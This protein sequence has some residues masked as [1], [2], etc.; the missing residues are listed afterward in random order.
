MSP[1]SEIRLFVIVPVYGNWDDTL[2]CLRALERQT[3]RDFQVLVADD[4]SPE[5]APDE[6]SRFGFADYS[7]GPNLGFAGNCNRAAARVLARGATHLFFLNNDTFFAPEFIAAIL[8]VI[9]RMPAAMLS[10][11][12]YWSRRPDRVWSSGGAFTILSP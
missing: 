12:V 7:R 10:P 1:G 3:T 8:H 2:E 11:V 6:I 4:G 9:R 5:S